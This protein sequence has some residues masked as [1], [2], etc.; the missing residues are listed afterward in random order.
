MAND[1]VGHKTLRAKSGQLYH[2]PLYRDEAEILLQKCKEADAKRAALMPDEESAIQMFFDAWQRLKE[3][4]WREACYCP[5][6]GSSFEVIEA[7]S[8]GIHPCYYSG[9]WPTGTYWVGDDLDISPSHP[10]L[11]RVPNAAKDGAK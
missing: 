3:L 2:E 10:V 5:K 7:G 4:G 11:F 1:I 9:E 8:T 6:D